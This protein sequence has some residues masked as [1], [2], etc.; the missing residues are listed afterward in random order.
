MTMAKFVRIIDAHRTTD[1]IV[2]D[3]A[4]ERAE[5]L[6]TG[7]LSEVQRVDQHVMAHQTL[8]RLREEQSD[9]ARRGDLAMAGQ[10]GERIRYWRS[11]V[12]TD[13]DLPTPDVEPEPAGDPPRP[14]DKPL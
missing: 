9:Y 5:H 7:R 8:A 13:V 3:L 11:M 1:S 10:L 4:A 12:D 14:V 6:A 2:G